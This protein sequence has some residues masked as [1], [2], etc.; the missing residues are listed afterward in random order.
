MGKNDDF[1]A[2]IARIHEQTNAPDP[3]GGMTTDPRQARMPELHAMP[4]TAASGTVSQPKVIFGSLATLAF[5]V[6]LLNPAQ[7]E[8]FEMAAAAQDTRASFSLFQALP[9]N[10]IADEDEQ[11]EIDFSTDISNGVKEIWGPKDHHV[12]ETDARV[13]LL[14]STDRPARGSVLDMMP[15]LQ[16][17][18]STDSQV[19]DANER[20]MNEV[21]SE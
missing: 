10:P 6:L 14:A 3:T 21:V 1:A 5:A 7:E 18:V 4:N 19:A 8:R 2:R 20:P 15:T 9:D 11:V 17:Y 12:T 13:A 16:R